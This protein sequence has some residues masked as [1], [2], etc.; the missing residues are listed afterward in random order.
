MDFSEKVQGELRKGWYLQGGV[1]VCILPTET[2]GRADLIYYQAVTKPEME[3][4][5]V[6]V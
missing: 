2:K 4:A 3:P 1:C 5:S 6:K